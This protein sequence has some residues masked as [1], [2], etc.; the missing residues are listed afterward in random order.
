MT[1]DRSIRYAFHPECGALTPMSPGDREAWRHDPFRP[2]LVRCDGC[3][4]PVPA[5]DLVWSDTGEPL[6]TWIAGLPS[7]APRP[8]RWL[9]L[10]I[11]PGGLAAIL[12]AALLFYTG[13]PMAL[14]LGAITGAVAGWLFEGPL[15]AALS[16]QFGASA[17]NATEIVPAILPMRPEHSS[18][19]DPEGPDQRPSD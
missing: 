9:N 16:R 13:R 19:E 10:A 15:R 6:D 1:D 2:P 5:S 3:P 4:E 12:A 18:L 7:D 17:S 14:I 11:S 8:L